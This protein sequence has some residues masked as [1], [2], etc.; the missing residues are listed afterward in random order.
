[1]NAPANQTVFTLANKITIVRIL[2]VPV[3]VLMLLYY[4]GSVEN[5]EPEE[6]YRA[7]AL[8]IFGAAAFTDALDGYVARSRGEITRLGRI[9]DPI[10][11]KSLL[12]SA[13]IMLTRHSFQ[14]LELHFPLWFILLIVSRDLVLFVGSAVVHALTGTVEVMPRIVGKIATFFQMFAVIWVLSGWVN[15]WFYAWV[16]MTGLFTFVAG[17][18]Y[19][20]DG[21]RQIEHSPTF[22]KLHHWTHHG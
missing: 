22:R 9:L 12:L 8:A 11:D 21:L 5:G 14:T 1:M 3:F 2:A 19:I 16:L 18:M 20:F 4:A 13:I 15:P 17:A 6:I 10:A 7:L